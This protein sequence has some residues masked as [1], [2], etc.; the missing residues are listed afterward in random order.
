MILAR[1]ASIALKS[2]LSAL[3]GA[4]LMASA[5]QAADYSPDQFFFSALIGP[6]P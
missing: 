6:G 4:V 1:E 2:F 5:A 3:V